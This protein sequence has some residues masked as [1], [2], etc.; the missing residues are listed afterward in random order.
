MNHGKMA[1]ACSEGSGGRVWVAL[2]AATIVGCSSR[3]PADILPVSDKPQVRLV[4]PE[5]R[6]ISRTIGQPGFVDACEQ[7]AI[8]AKLSGYLEKW[9]VDINDRVT[10]DQVL[11]TL[12]IPE[13]IQEHEQR[14]AAVVRSQALVDQ[15][16]KLVEVA[17]ANL[18]AASAQVAEAKAT[19][20]KYQ[21]LVERW[22]SE[23]KRPTTL[24]PQKVLDQQV[25][26]ES[27]RQLQASIAS[28][29]A[30]EAELRTAT[31]NQTAVRA[32]LAKATVDVAVAKAN[33]QVAQ[34]DERR[35]SALVGY[36]RLTS[37]Y[38]GIVVAR[39]ANTGDFVLPATGDPSAEPRSSDQ[40]S[41][42]AAPIYVSARTDIVRV[43]VDVPET[44]ANFV[45]SEV[46]RTNGSSR[47]VTSA[48]VRIQALQDDEIP[49]TVTRTSWGLNVRSRTL[50]AEIDLPTPQARIAPGMYAYGRVRIDRPGSLGRASPGA[51]R[52]RQ[53]VVLLPPPRG[54]SGAHAGAGRRQRWELAG[55][56]PEADRP[57]LGRVDRRG[58]GV[59]RRPVGVGRRHRGRGRE[60]GLGHPGGA[61]V[62]Q[63]PHSPCS[64]F[65]RW[66]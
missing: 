34:A 14:K 45:V 42:R 60:I 47:P 2:L 39:N 30:A 29:D 12:F 24:V 56:G 25:L 40:S 3:A 35:L 52:D 53:P 66:V 54:Q 27:V 41:A 49:A 7:T 16:N 61:G 63:T 62:A 48:W 23:V 5:R 4:N 38:D 59:A 22:Q 55:S 8:Y 37:P 6:T 31:A 21:A 1:T 58:P 19:I 28:R 32:A 44:E 15:A 13:L 46:D 11:A 9:Y 64:C 65:G 18:Q 17:E 50:R 57:R 26:D 10:K 20:G 51:G 43:Y 33:L 36:T